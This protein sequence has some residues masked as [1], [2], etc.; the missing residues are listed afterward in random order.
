M[1]RVEPAIIAGLLRPYASLPEKLINQIST[2]I[3]VLLKWNSKIN[4]TSVRDP[5]EIVRRHFGE[6][7]FLAATLLEQ[8]WR[9]TVVDVGSGAGFPG[10]P[11]AMYRPAANVTLIE[12]QGKK[13]AFL[14]EVIYALKL[15]N[16]KVFHGRAEVFPGQADL[17]TLRAVEDFERVIKVAIDL[18]AGGGRIALMIG[19]SQLPKAKQVDS[20]EWNEPLPVPG[21][22]ARL[23]LVGIK[24]ENV[25]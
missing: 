23:L 8:D 6:S 5:Q 10:L 7:L 20:L 12:S 25:E 18:V 21:G 15:T 1:E 14:N 13:A 19:S 4:L 24:K 2:Y 22:Q 11:L 9:G 16:A 3:D 17:V